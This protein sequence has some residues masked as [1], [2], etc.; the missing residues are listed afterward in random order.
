MIH[1]SRLLFLQLLAPTC[2]IL[3]DLFSNSSSVIIVIT[4]CSSQT[5]IL[6]VS[7][8]SVSLCF[9]STVF[10]ISL[11]WIFWDF[12]MVNSPLWFVYGALFFFL[13]FMMFDNKVLH[14]QNIDYVLGKFF[15]FYY[16]FSSIFIYLKVDWYI[17]VDLLRWPINYY[18]QKQKKLGN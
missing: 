18:L 9:F 17:L 14:F 15:Y 12:S 16:V 13:S 2:I 8:F 11:L 4:M 6:Y 10:A 3:C 7:F 1:L 5:I